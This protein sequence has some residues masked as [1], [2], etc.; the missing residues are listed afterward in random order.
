M[1]LKNAAVNRVE[2]MPNSALLNEENFMQHVPIPDNSTL[3]LS[4]GFVVIPRLGEWWR[5]FSVDVGNSGI[6]RNAYGMQF[7]IEEKVIPSY[8]INDLLSKKVAQV[9]ESESRIMGRKER[10]EHRDNILI[11]LLPKA[12]IRKVSVPVFIVHNNHK[13]Q[14]VICSLTGKNRVRLMDALI[15]TFGAMKVKIIVFDGISQG[16]SA[17]LKNTIE[18]KSGLYDIS[19]DVLTFGQYV[20]VG[21][22]LL[23]RKSE[24]IRMQINEVDNDNLLD[25]LSAEDP[26]RVTELVLGDNDEEKVP[27]N[28]FKIDINFNFKSIKW[29]D[30]EIEPEAKED[31][32][33]EWVALATIRC[34]AIVKW[35]ND[36]CAQ[37]GFKTEDEA[38]A[39]TF[40]DLDV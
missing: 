26:F 33:H 30:V 13:E 25:F 21:N 15:K 18:I 4:Y 11:S 7:F 10:E 16:I 34:T 20:P 28:Y 14:T 39:D 32:A 27:T 24:K 17:R 22:L 12:A 23:K 35:V 2:G 37:F 31:L 40:P 36:F 9:E 1:F 29:S 5:E 8:Q 19:D 3:H 38:P 6:M